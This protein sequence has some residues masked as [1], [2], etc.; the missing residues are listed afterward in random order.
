M[1]TDLEFMLHAITWLDEHE[2]KLPE[3]WVHLRPTAPLRDIALI[4]N[5]IEQM[6]AD[7]TAD[8]LRSAHKT[9]V[10]P[11][12]WFW[13]SEDGYYQTFNGITLDEAN[14]P[15]QGFPTMYIP[16]G[17]VDVLKTQY[18]VEHHLLHGK[19]MIGFEVPDTVD[20]DTQREFE[21][22]AGVIGGSDDRI[23]RYMEQCENTG[24]SI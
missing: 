21:E 15:R 3:F 2:D 14:G 23:M 22:A 16:D 1:A 5:A 19:R 11:F 18:I 12:K 24:E 17:Y 7:P 10:C 20:I 9:D 6:A 13:M 4:Q 8:S